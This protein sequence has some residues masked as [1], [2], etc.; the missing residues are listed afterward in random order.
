MLYQGKIHNN[1]VDE[2]QVLDQIPFAE[3]KQNYGFL[4]LR[5]FASQH[6]PGKQPD[7]QWLL[8]LQL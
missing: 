7:Q 6:M 3:M 1:P 4:N 5:N 8:Q 2:R